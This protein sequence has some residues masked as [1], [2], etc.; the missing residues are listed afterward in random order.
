MDRRNALVMISGVVLSESSLSVADGA[1]AQTAV[2]KLGL[3][4]TWAASDTGRYR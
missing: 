3:L 1:L 4:A 2:L